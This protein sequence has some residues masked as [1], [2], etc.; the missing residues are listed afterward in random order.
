VS[1]FDFQLLTNLMI[2][3][4]FVVVMVGVDLDFFTLA[5]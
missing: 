4:G 2:A 3:L 1:I 5:S